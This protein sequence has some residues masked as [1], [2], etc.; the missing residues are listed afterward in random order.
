[1][2]PEAGTAPAPEDDESS[3]EEEGKEDS[4]K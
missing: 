1:L 4:K 2:V 3:D